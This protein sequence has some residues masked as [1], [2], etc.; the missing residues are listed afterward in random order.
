MRS[1]LLSSVFA[2][3]LL[4]AALTAVGLVSALIG[5]GLWDALSWVTLGVPVGC[6]V[7]LWFCR[8]GQPA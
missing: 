7:W 4:L 2:V 5:D 6:V 1:W 8:M 3:P